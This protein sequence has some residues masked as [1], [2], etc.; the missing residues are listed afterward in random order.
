M[1]FEN[2]V[3]Y[4]LQYTGTDSMF[5][6]QTS[7]DP[8]GDHYSIVTHYARFT[9]VQ[10]KAKVEELKAAGVVDDLENLMM[11][12]KFLQ[13]AIYHDLEARITNGRTE[14]LTNGPMFF[15]HVISEL[16]SETYRADKLRVLGLRS[17]PGEDVKALNVLIS[18]YCKF[19]AGSGPL[20]REI[21]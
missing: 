10:F 14:T 19:L 11:S 18:T 21:L 6:F 9:E 15:M 17:I 12:C 7:A 16:Q 8:S 13:K 4:N 1:Q 5:Y 3:S 2:Y 20:R